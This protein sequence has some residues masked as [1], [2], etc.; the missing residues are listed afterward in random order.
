MPNS[1]KTILLLGVLTGLLLWAGNQFGGQSGLIIAFIFAVGMNVFGFWFSDKIVLKMYRAKEVDESSAPELYRLVSN[2]A[3]QASLP[4]PKVYI[5]PMQEPNAFATGRNPDHAAV[6]V[7]E[8]IM[9]LMNY[10]ELSGVIAHELAHIKNRDTL[11][12]TISAILAGAVMML[13]T[14]AR[15][16]A[17]FGGF[18]DDEDGGGIAEL[19]VL[20]FVT[21]IVALIIQMAISRTREHK[22]DA[23]GAQ[24]AGNPFGLANGLEKL[25][26]YSGKTRAAAQHASSAHM[27]IMNPL[28][29]KGFLQLISTHPPI[30]KRVEKLRSIG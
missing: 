7:T 20:M 11:I 19:L 18:G 30:E 27:M 28:S 14:M 3:S 16:G 22:A 17:I 13:A 2:L 10:D 24:I 12:S 25:S 9:R 26:H 21:P 4:M 6:A 1:L 23:T 5:V 8:G 15:W 29:G